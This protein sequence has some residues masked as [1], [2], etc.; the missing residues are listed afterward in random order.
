[1]SIGTFIA[2]FLF[3]LADSVMYIALSWWVLKSFK[4]HRFGVA[5]FLILIFPFVYPLVYAGSLFNVFWM[6]MFSPF[7]GLIIMIMVFPV[8]MLLYYA[9]TFGTLLVLLFSRKKFERFIKRS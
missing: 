2:Y 5:S 8:L 3:V 1:M 9:I 7:Y 6:L 4:H